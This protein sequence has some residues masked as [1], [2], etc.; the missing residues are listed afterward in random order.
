MGLCE[1][2]VDRLRRRRRLVMGA[3]Y[4]V[5]NQTTWKSPIELDGIGAGANTLVGATPAALKRKHTS[6][7]AQYTDFVSSPSTLLILSR[8]TQPYIIIRKRVCRVLLS[9]FR[10]PLP[11]FYRS[12]STS[13]AAQSMRSELSS[14]L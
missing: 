13:W 12:L 7:L 5:V 10:V 1:G 4:N 9:A 6:P 8:K 3:V 14:M 2:G 11:P